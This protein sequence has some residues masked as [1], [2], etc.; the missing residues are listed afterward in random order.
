MPLTRTTTIRII[1]I[2]SLIIVVVI[3]VAYGVSRSLNYARGPKID[4]YNPANGTVAT[5]SMI[6]IVGRVERAHNLFLNG[7]PVTVDE[8]GNFKEN[9]LVF[10][11]INIITM[12]ADDQFGRNTEI[13]RTLVW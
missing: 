8:Q 11:G 5:S 2:T 10:K 13:T 3:I 4:I 12:R 9:I 1:K 6:E 7:H